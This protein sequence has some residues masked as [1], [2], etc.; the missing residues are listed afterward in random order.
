MQLLCRRYSTTNTE[1]ASGYKD[2]TMRVSDITTRQVE[3]TLEA[4]SNSV[5]ILSERALLNLERVG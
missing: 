3:Q 1:Y 2:Q 5:K 4:Y